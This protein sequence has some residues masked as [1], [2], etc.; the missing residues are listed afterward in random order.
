MFHS[1]LLF[2]PNLKCSTKGLLSKS[3]LR[4]LELM[5]AMV[6]LLGLCYL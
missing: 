1:I 2:I 6:V 5:F 4:W 3:L